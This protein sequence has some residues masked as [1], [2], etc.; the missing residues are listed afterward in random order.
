V[1]RLKGWCSLLI[2]AAV[3]L[4]A[5]SSGSRASDPAGTAVREAH[6]SVAALVLSV[7]LSLQGKATTQVTQVSLEQCLEDVAAAQQEVLTATD[8][9]A[10][11]KAVAWAA[12]KSAADSLVALSDRGADGLGQPELDRLKAVEGALAAAS[13]EL[14]A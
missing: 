2:V 12:V 4:S 1:R 5:C 8:A 6:T 11:R 14:Q 13:R 9:D 7:Q 3:T 10:Q